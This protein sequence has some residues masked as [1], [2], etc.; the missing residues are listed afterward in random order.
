ME[1]YSWKYP[2]C[3]CPTTGFGVLDLADLLTRSGSTCDL[4]NSD[5]WLHGSFLPQL[6]SSWPACDFPS[7]TINI[8]AALPIN[9]SSDLTISLMQ[10]NQSLSKV[11][12]A[13]T[14]INKSC[15]TW[16]QNPQP[17]APWNSIKNSIL[18]HLSSASA[19]ETIA[20]NKLKHSSFNP[21]KASFTSQITISDP[22]L[23][24]HWSARRASWQSALLLCQHILQVLSYKQVKFL[25][26]GVFKMIADV[27]KSCPSSIKLCKKSFPD[28]NADVP[29]I[30]HTVH[31]LFLFF[32][33][34][35]ASQ[36]NVQLKRWI[37]VVLCELSI[38][39]S[40]SSQSIT[41]GFRRTFAWRGTPD[42]IGSTLAWR[43]STHR[44]KS[45]PHSRSI[46]RPS[47]SGSP[48]PNTKLV[49]GPQSTTE[50]K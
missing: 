46:L 35:L 15:R 28:F 42:I 16:R 45:S 12:K 30:L 21:W 36:D 18:S 9:Q 13:L 1:P 7:R 25:I 34:I 37:L 2:L 47:S 6:K 19:S 40:Y 44:W 26:P 20:T 3:S 32:S 22:N 11:I 24:F 43:W 4:I 8:I 48:S 29:N 39:K 14:L 23:E 5:F 50:E 17:T 31:P 27:K 38:W 10:H 49:L 33:P 41:R